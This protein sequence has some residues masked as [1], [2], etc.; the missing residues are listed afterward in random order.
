MTLLCVL[1]CVRHCEE[2]Y[3]RR[4]NPLAAASWVEGRGGVLCSPLVSNSCHCPR[5]LSRLFGL[6][7]L[8]CLFCMSVYSVVAG[9]ENISHD[10][11]EA[12]LK[13]RIE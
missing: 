3:A 6:F 2:G 9:V 12:L 5:P 13:V 7:G 1:M 10:L 4:G 8:S 11:G